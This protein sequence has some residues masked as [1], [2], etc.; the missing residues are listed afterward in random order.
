MIKICTAERM[1][2]IDRDAVEIVGIP[3]I[4]LMENAGMACVKKLNELGLAGRRVAVFCGK[5]NNGGDGF[6]IARHLLEMGIET[7][8]FLVCGKDFKGD[9]L[10]NYNIL[11]KMNIPMS[12]IS[13]EE[14]LR[15]KIKSFDI[16]VDAI[17][18]TGIS[19]GISGAAKNAIESINRY[20][21]TVLSVD[22][23]SG[24]NA[25]NGEIAG[26][27]VKA[28]YTVTFCAYKRGM[29]LFPSADFCGKTEVAGISIPEYIYGDINTNVID[30]NLAL[31]VMPKRVDNSHKGSYGKVLIIGGS[32]GMTG[33]PVM[34][35]E[36]ALKCGVGLVSVAIPESLNGILEEKLTEAM[37][38][39]MTDKD[40]AFSAEAVDDIIKSAKNADAVVFCPGIGRGTD[41]VTILEALL[42]NTSLPVIVDADGLYALAKKPDCL[43][44]HGKKLILTPHEGE[45][46]RLAGK[47]VS[48][49]NRFDISAEFCR[50]FNTTLV[51]KGNKTIVTA[52]DSKQYTNIAGNNGMAT[53]GSGDV[54]AG[55]IGAFSARGKNPEE[56]AMLGVYCHSL[57]GDAAAETV[58]RD[59]LT[60]TDII[61][62]IHLILPVE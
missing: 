50:E 42:E 12:E 7:E 49:K 55:M 28:D 61:S 31:S 59:S 11:E 35:A 20:A 46:L 9:A 53:A 40:G 54:L 38:I 29:L 32:A 45:F 57:A 6:V 21:E 22:I 60:A 13:A 26:V 23:P 10:V 33:A 27:A 24:V 1:R 15:Y 44:K 47:A 56:S 30:K 48:Q 17:F 41:I 8:V 37:T 36:A 58:G 34:A 25:D 4:V 5:G 51:L 18:G 52:Q 2:K 39:P 19:G 43:K 3:S 16:V 14:D 62:S